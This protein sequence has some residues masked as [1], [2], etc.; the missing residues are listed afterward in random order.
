MTNSKCSK[1]FKDKVKDY[2]ISESNGI[3][4]TSWNKFKNYFNYFTLSGEN[5]YHSISE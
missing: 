3:V 2:I 1:K 5:K 4:N